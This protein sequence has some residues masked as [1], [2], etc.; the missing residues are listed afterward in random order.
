MAVLGISTLALA[1][2]PHPVCYL[3]DFG[4][5]IEQFST[6]SKAD[7]NRCIRYP[8]KYIVDDRLF[9]N[10]KALDDYAYE[11]R[12]FV[13]S[14]GD[15]DIK[16]RSDPFF[17][18]GEFRN[19]QADKFGYVYNFHDDGMDLMLVRGHDTFIYEGLTFEYINKQWMITTVIGSEEEW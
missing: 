4:A 10:Q 15:I 16:E 1:A 12:R 9:R 18:S 3:S 7:Q 6:L 13:Y 11:G 8:V 2:D 14:P 17:G 5:F 19:I